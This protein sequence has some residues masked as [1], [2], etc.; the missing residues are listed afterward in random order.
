MEEVI[1]Y[2]RGAALFVSA[3]SFLFGVSIFYINSKRDRIKKTIEHWEEINKELFISMKK[4]KQV[5]K[6]AISTT[7]GEYM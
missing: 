5:Q 7:I 6:G 4:I 3:L 2:I 1:H